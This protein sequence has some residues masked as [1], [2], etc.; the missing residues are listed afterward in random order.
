MLKVGQ[1]I[2]CVITD[3]NKESRRIAISFKLTQEN[4]FTSFSKKY[5]L[6]TICEGIVVS[7][8]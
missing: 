3:I 7:K 6:D 5:P 2:S 8:N 4:P 1:E